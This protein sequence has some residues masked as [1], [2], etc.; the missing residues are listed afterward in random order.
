MKWLK[1]IMPLLI[2]LISVAFANTANAM[3]IKHDVN[4]YRNGKLQRYV[5]QAD[6]VGTF[7]E[8]EGIALNVSE[9][10]E[11]TPETKL[12][13]YGVTEI[14]IDR[15]I[16]LSVVTD[17]VAETM[18]AP[19]NEIT[20]NFVQRL[21]T[22]RAQRLHLESPK[23]GAPLKDGSK[24]TLSTV[25]QKTVM[26]KEPIPFD[27]QYVSN[28]TL[29]AG[30]ESMVQAGVDG[31][32][33]IRTRITFAGSKQ[34]EAAESVENIVRE[35]V[36]EIIHRGTRALQTKQPDTEQPT[37]YTAKYTMNASAYTAGYESTGKNPGDKGYGITA[38]GEKARHGI[39]AVDPSVIPLGK[40]V[41]VEGYGYA[42]AADTGSAIKG[43]KIDVFYDRLSDALNFGRKNVTVYVLN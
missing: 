11:L 38:T 31:E 16:K 5:T 40:K 27:T 6:T 8:S 35:P 21:Q 17:G 9:S 24:V 7:L 29:P 14:R 19:K 39:V 28:S 4:V 3:G 33:E 12:D 2:V 18:Y 20:G 22:E 42:M 30:V 37:Y 26:K 32:K 23:A 36:T 34:L 15:G 10:L 41:Y 13:A 25:T 43:H 1:G